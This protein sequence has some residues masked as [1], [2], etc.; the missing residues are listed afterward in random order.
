MKRL[1]ASANTSKGKRT[2]ADSDKDHK[3][4]KGKKKHKPGEKKSYTCLTRRRWNQKHVTNSSCKAQRQKAGRVKPPLVRSLGWER[5][6]KL[7]HPPQTLETA[8]ESLASRNTPAIWAPRADMQFLATL[9][10]AEIQASSP[11]KKRLVATSEW[12]T[13]FSKKR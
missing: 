5:S 13:K 9:L 12:F 7:T 4:H 10:H 8:L 3:R 2:V 11:V 1:R 6:E